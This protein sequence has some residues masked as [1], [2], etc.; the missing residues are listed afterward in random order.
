MI[1]EGD[2]AAHKAHFC[3]PHLVWNWNGTEIERERARKN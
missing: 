1:F 3:R 2:V